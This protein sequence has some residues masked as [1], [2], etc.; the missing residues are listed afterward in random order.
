MFK[1]RCQLLSLKLVHSKKHSGFSQTHKIGNNANYCIRSFTM[2]KQ[3]IPVTKCCPPMSNEPRPLISLWFQVQHFCKSGQTWHLLIKLRLQ[4]LYS[5]ALLILTKSHKSKNQ[6]A[7]EQ[8]C[9]DLSST[10]HISPERRVL[11]LESEARGSIL[12]G[13][14]IL[15][16]EFFV[17]L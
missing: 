3:K 8:K 16:L 12:T 15:S 6:V 13:D 11:D 10:C 5:H 1:A 7:H 4:A 17:F 2:W 14:N 9:K